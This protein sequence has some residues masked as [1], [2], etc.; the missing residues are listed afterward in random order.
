MTITLTKVDL[1]PGLSLT[2]TYADATAAGTPG[3]YSF[4]ASEQSSPVGTLTALAQSPTVQVTCPD[5]TG[6]VGVSPTTVAASS[7]D[8]LTFTYTAAGSC[9]VPNGGEV[10]MTIPDDWPRPSNGHGTAGYTSS[11]LFG[12]PALAGRTVTVTV[13]G[14]RLA[15]GQPLTISYAAARAPATPRADMFKFSEQSSGSGTLAA[16]GPVTVNVAR[17]GTM[18]VRPARVRAAQRTALVFTYTAGG[19]GLAPSGEVTLRVPR[20]WARPS[21]A[22]GRAGYTSAS[23]GSLSV[24]G[25]LITGTGVSLRPGHK[26]K[27]TYR[28]GAAPSRPGAWTFTASESTAGTATPA[29]L[30]ASPSVTV[31]P[32]PPPW[33]LWLIIFLAVGLLTAAFAVALAVRHHIRNRKPPRVEVKPNPG[34][35]GQV[36]VRNT[37]TDPTITVH[38]QP[39]PGDAVIDV[40]RTST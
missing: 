27:I 2:I 40:E 33:P 28:A 7:V 37:G 14:G 12:P 34:L 1:A 32:P 18:I 22:H 30:A 24:H 6:T 15:P 38:I 20:G 31:T 19:A 36:S 4:A 25:R 23:A 11:S 29:A 13:T 39:D 35:P 8:T 21:T 5:G 16:I 26:L 9:G 17:P 10:T 3:R